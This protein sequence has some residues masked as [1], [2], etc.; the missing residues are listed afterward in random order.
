MAQQANGDVQAGTYL[1]QAC[2]KP[3]RTSDSVCVPCPNDCAIGHYRA[4]CGL[5]GVGTCGQM[6]S[7][8]IQAENIAM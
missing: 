4:G 8:M 2:D 6:L 7:V 5:A 3:A 1:S